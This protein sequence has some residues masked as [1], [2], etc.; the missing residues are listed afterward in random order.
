VAGNTGYDIVVPGVVFA[1][2][3]IEGG[4]FQPLDKAKLTNLKNLDPL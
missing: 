4:L 1:K 2:P 3:Q